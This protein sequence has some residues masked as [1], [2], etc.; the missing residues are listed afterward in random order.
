MDVSTQTIELCDDHGALELLG[1]SECCLELWATL[2]CI[3]ALAALNLNKFLNEFQ[4]FSLGEL[5]QGRALC[6]KP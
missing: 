2:D 6:S 3:A 4:A 1:C 5:S